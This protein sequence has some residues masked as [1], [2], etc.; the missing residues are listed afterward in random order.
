MKLRF[1]YGLVGNLI[2][3]GGSAACL[4][5]LGYLIFISTNAKVDTASMNDIIN[6]EPK[7]INRMEALAKQDEQKL[8]QSTLNQNDTREKYI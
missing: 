8:E 4:G 5:Y 6:R 3:F 7:R 2:F 1:R